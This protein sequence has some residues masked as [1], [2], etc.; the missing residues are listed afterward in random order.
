MA[1]A[2]LFVTVNQV[3]WPSGQYD[4]LVSEL[5]NLIRGTPPASISGILIAS[6]SV[7][8]HQVFLGEQP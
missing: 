4:C 7:G 3:S 8:R 2:R 5:G 1:E 6:L